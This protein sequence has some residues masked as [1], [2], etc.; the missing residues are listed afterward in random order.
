MGMTVRRMIAYNHAM[1]WL[2]A[3]AFDGLE[4]LEDA[5]WAYAVGDGAAYV[6]P[7]DDAVLVEDEGGGSG[8]AGFDEAVDHIGLGDGAVGV[9]E[10][11]EE[12]AAD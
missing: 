11:G 12:D 1:L 3:L 9:V 4:L 8:A 5:V 7:G 10:D 2:E 6:L